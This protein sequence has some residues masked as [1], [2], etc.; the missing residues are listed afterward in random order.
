MA[1]AEA[2]QRVLRRTAVAALLFVGLVVARNTALPYL[3]G[4]ASR[5]HF[6]GVELAGAVEDIWRREAGGPLPVVTGSWWPAA[7]VGLHVDD[8]VAVYD[9]F[10]PEWSPW[11]GDATLRE[12]G[13]VIV[14]D[15]ASAEAFARE[16]PRRFPDARML[17][18]IELPWQ[19][20]AAVAPG[21][22]GVA[23]V[24]PPAARVARS[25][26]AD[27]AATR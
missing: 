12:R 7:N 23:I 1:S 5:V 11:A 6:P 18:D 26:P 10:Q 24:L 9:F 19:T 21:R 2:C 14:C 22:I 3:K 20:G 16:V 8:N 25:T 27:G 4:K 17:S 15:E 13:G